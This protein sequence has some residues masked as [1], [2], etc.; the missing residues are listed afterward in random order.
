MKKFILTLAALCSVAM[1]TT[2][3]NTIEGA[4][5]DIERA[6]DKIEKSAQ[7]NK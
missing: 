5:R 1:F 2:G 6:G 3:C 4:G 7:R